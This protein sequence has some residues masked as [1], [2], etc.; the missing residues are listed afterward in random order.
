MCPSWLT[1]ASRC[2]RQAVEKPN[3][4]LKQAGQKLKLQ[5]VVIAALGELKSVHD[6]GISQAELVQWWTTAKKEIRRHRDAVS[7]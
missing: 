6:D 4:V 1:S 7:A 3:K 5:K 2:L